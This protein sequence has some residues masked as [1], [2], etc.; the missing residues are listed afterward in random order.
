M[1]N[2]QGDFVWYELLTTDSAKAREFYSKVLGWTHADSGMAGASYWLASAQDAD[3]G[4]KHEIAGIMELTA[5]M[6]AAGAQPAWMGYI[7]VDNTD[8]TV[9]A[10]KA[11][12]GGVHVPPTDIPGVG[13]FAMIH[14]PQGVNFYIMQDTSGGHS[15]AFAD[16]K[17]R[18]GHCA[19]N[20]LYTTDQAG[21][22]AFYSKHF[23][24]TKDG[25]MDMGPMGTYDFIRHGGMIG[26][27]MRKPDEQPVACWQFYFRVADINSAQDTIKANGGQVFMG[28]QEVP[29]G[30]FIIVGMDPTGAV[31]AVVGAAAEG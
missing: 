22:W 21:A 7:G 2:K 18:V 8:A 4:D 25:D 28:P 10:I 30:D 23:G 31:F 14:D 26:A 29:G 27:M 19:W 5:E 12:G 20:E 6:S 3:T 1:S 24:W 15:L 11:D 13:R 16:D 17:P 9:A